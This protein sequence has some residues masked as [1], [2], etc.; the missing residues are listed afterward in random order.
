MRVWGILVMVAA[1]QSN[2]QAQDSLA[3][4]K[5]YDRQIN[6]RVFL[7]NKYTGLRIKTDTDNIKY[8]PVTTL[9]P[10]IGFTYEWLTI[11]LGYGF[12]LVNAESRD[13][14]TRTLDFQ[15]HAYGR[16]IIVDALAQF[17]KGYRLAG[18]DRIREDISAN[19]MGATAQYVF[20][21]RQFSYRA[22]F[23]QSEWQHRSAGTW[24]AGVSVYGGRVK[25]DSSMIPASRS[26]VAP[27][28]ETR[29]FE[30]GPSAGYAYT[31]VYRRHYFATASASASLDVSF[32]RSGE[33][34]GS[35]SGVGI[36]PNTLLKLFIG[37]NSERWAI[38]G[39]YI[40][41]DLRL[42]SINDNSRLTL[43][44]GTYR[45]HFVYR[46]KPGPKARKILKPV[47]DVEKQIDT[48]KEKYP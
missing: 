44:N 16:K 9:S 21:A 39:M 13:A 11:N 3:Y 6:G 46:F 38:T 20:N 34:N 47:D 37:Y 33:S 2:A 35:V 1:L 18:Q 17:Y 29:F 42:I 40:G 27:L 25:A 7:A 4:Y 23:L 45:L 14:D 41:N 28:N 5:A 31:Y 22:A 24:L 30:V 43:L 10:G 15:F 8:R 32:V 12:P 36:S 19:A 48:I 26:E